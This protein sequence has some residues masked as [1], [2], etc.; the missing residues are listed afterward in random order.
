MNKLNCL[1]VRLLHAI[2]FSL[3]NIL[4]MPAFAGATGVND[5]TIK[6][7]AVNG[8][9]DS[10]NPGLTCIQLPDAV[11]VSQLSAACVGGWIAIQ[12][13]NKSLIAAALT[14]RANNS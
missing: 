14:A 9:A 11:G 10:S 3:S 12:N 1:H 6:Q 2:L 8:G 4:S 5:T 13:N 7:I